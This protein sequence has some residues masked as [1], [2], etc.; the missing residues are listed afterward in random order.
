[1]ELTPEQRLAQAFLIM[2]G[3]VDGVSADQADKELQQLYEKKTN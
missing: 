1:M 3:Y 2:M